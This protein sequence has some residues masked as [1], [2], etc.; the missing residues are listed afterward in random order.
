MTTKPHPLAD[1]DGTEQ[2]QAL[3]TLADRL[4]GA[5]WR[6]ASPS[7]SLIRVPG[8]QSGSGAWSD[9]LEGF[10]RTFLAAAFRVRGADGDDPHGHLE[11]YA[12]GL[13]AG[14]DPAGDER[15]P[16]ITERRQAVPEAASIAICLAETRP[17]LWDRLPDRTRQQVIEWMSG[18]L[19]MTGFRSNWLWFQNV[20]EAF[21]VSVGSDADPDDLARN[22]AFAES[23]Y[24]GDGW[25]SDSFGRDG[26][27]Q[28]FDWYAGWAWH[29][30]PLFESRIRGEQLADV[31]R[32]RLRAFLDQARHLIGSAGAPVL[33]GRSAGY[34]FATLAPFWAG[35]LADATPLAT[36]RTREIAARSIGHFLDA[37]AIDEA[38]LLSI[39][40]HREFTPIRQFYSGSSSPYW[41]S[42]GL[43]GLLLPAEHEEWATQVPAPVERGE[44]TT[45]LAVPGW[46]VVE[47]PEDGIVRVLNHGSDRMHEARIAVRADDPFYRR[48]GYSNATSPQLGADAVAAPRESN[49]TLLD[50]QGL[51]AHRDGIERI[52]FGERVAV[53][54]SRVHWLDTP[55]SIHPSA[56]AGW[57]GLRRGP[58]LTVASV[59]NKATELRVAWWSAVARS[60]GQACSAAEADAEAL[61]PVDAGPWRMSFGGWPL[62]SADVT[63]EAVLAEARVTTGSRHSV[64]RGLG[65][66]AAGRIIRREGTDPFASVSLTP[67]VETLGPVPERTLTAALISFASEP[68]H[69][70]EPAVLISG[71]GIEIRWPDGQMDLVPTREK[72][73]W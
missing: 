44:R 18:I 73:T 45:A 26:E 13:A 51:P 21:L 33:I 59:V 52:H 38:G 23:L 28:S 43:M 12:A 68:C 50:A 24:V 36:G 53:S 7:G 54:R 60:T 63:G 5:A 29:V 55:G 67:V 11:R 14:V 40:W 46:L 20:I 25:Y 16:R 58:V 3:L 17:W 34:R 27:R 32:D 42:K 70:H 22:E 48:I 41:A 39:G 47:T 49:A 1:A 71:G 65:P 69:L 64:V 4:V 10:A 37:G 8:P 56:D 57:A 30:Y 19:G 66:D 72:V 35:V 9:G 31:H 2:R 61:W 62:A 15:W 6:H